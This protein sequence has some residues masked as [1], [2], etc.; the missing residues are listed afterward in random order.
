MYLLSLKVACRNFISNKFLSAVNLLGL[1][2]GVSTC[3][4]ILM[5]VYNE[6]NYDMFNEKSE[7]IYRVV[8]DLPAE[9]A[10]Q[11]MYAGVAPAVG[12]FIKNVCP[13]I[14]SFSI[15]VTH[16]DQGAVLR[17]GDNI[18]KELRIYETNSDF[19]KI[20]TLTVTSRLKDDLLS[21]PYEMV[22]TKSSAMK[23][24]GNKNPLGEY[25]ILNNNE[26]YLVVGVVDDFPKNSHLAFDI[27]FSYATPEEHFRTPD[28]RSLNEIWEWYGFPTY[29]LCNG[30]ADV[31]TLE[32][33]INRVT[34][35]YMEKIAPEASFSLQPITDI[36]L[37]SDYLFELQKNG[38]F[39]NVL[40]LFFVAV[41]IICISVVNYVNLSVAQNAKRIKEVGVK[42]CLG[43]TQQNMMK[44]LLLESSLFILG[45]F[46]LAFLVLLVFSPVFNEITA[47]NIN[48]FS[49][50]SISVTLACSA[51][52]FLFTLLFSF[53]PVVLLSSV[54]VVNV[55]KGKHKKSSFGKV[56]GKLL[57]VSQFG[58]SSFTIGVTLLIILQLSFMQNQ[59]IG[60]SLSQKIIINE[61]VTFDYTNQKIKPFIESLKE[62]PQITDICRTSHPPGTPTNWICNDM[63]QSKDGDEPGFTANLIAIDHRYFTCYDIRI[64]AGRGF[65]D[66][67]AEKNA[68]ILNKTAAEKFGFK[69]L[70][71][72]IGEK[73]YMYNEEMTVI[74]VVADYYHLSLKVSHLPYYFVYKKEGLGIPMK[75][76]VSVNAADM[77]A[78]LADINRTWTSFFPEQVFEFEYL[79]DKY[80][81]Q[82][83]EE[84]QFQHLFLI[85]SF[86]CIIIAGIGLLGL[87]FNEIANQRRNI[88]IRK[89]LGAS[90]RKL[91][92]LLTKD[93]FILVL[94]SQLI[95][96]PVIIYFKN[97]W[98]SYFPYKVDIGVWVYFVPLLLLLVFSLLTISYNV[99]RATRL[100]PVDALK[101][102]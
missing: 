43:A 35:E 13:E 87:T 58:I 18:F 32:N 25:M 14:E 37:K 20:F 39:R 3:I 55:L 72:C 71:K 9:N 33:K 73:L 31:K 7:R 48:A 52:I 56:M 100:N 41:L 17:Y 36:H 10:S 49:S 64:L 67:E 34:K 50:E 27:L 57:V 69:E 90:F 94:V 11:S 1:S 86:I 24:F 5:Y 91:Y 38:D 83:V 40:I 12:P 74:G 76:T 6:F 51:A 15:F 61:P 92:F 42:K 62:N 4:M 77:K 44:H 2:V 102:E 85:F 81:E 99:V 22:L 78:V 19:F 70:D 68:I 97:K 8:M 75:I 80:Q 93:I 54:K 59:D 47:G 26:K 96:F 88:A 63:K 65:K 95:S 89:V 84:I 98:M 46:I 28:G 23:Y 53:Y 30:E 79:E 60:F 29:I 101:E 66:S 16:N 45:S 82:Y 21:R